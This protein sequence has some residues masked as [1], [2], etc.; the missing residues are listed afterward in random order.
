[1][2]VSKSRQTKIINAIKSGS[3]D[4]RVTGKSTDGQRWPDPNH[5]FIVDDLNLQQTIHIS[6]D[7]LSTENQ[8]IM[9]N[10]IKK[11]VSEQ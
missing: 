7:S 3:T 8:Q 2:K 4:Y 1:M 5:F 9:E 11:Y 10:E 6:V